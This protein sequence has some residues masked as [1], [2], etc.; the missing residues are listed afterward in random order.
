MDPH[1]KGALIG[2][3]STFSAMGLGY[4]IKKSYSANNMPLLADKEQGAP[5][6]V[7]SAT[8]ATPQQT[9]QVESEKD[10][11]I[12]LLGDVGGTNIRLILSHI[13]LSERDRR[14]TIKEQ[15][16]DSRSVQSFEEAVKNFLK[17][18]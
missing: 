7:N 6:Q 17:V 8:A 18:S 3:I 5:T 4:L 2:G 9:E 13:Y 12:V 16:V 11:Y 10:D 15:T 1:V 14:V